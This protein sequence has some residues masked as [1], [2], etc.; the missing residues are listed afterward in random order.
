MA[1]AR[2]SRRAWFAVAGGIAVRRR[3]GSCRVEVE[4]TR[5]GSSFGGG[6]CA[7]HLRRSRG[8][9]ADARRQAAAGADQPARGAEPVTWSVAT[10][11]GPLRPAAP[12]WPSTCERWRPASSPSWTRRCSSSSAACSA[13]RTTPATRSTSCSRIRLRSCPSGRCRTGSTCSR[14]CVARLP[15]DS[16]SWLHAGWDAEGRRASQRR[17]GW[18]SA[19]CSGRRR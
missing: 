1:P 2:L 16:C 15:S 18:R 12:R 19:R 13:S 17:S 10:S 7:G 11:S 3:V 14:R 4:R 9:D 8:L 5:R 6:R